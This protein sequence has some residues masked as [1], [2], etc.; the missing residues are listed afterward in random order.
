MGISKNDIDSLTYSEIRSYAFAKAES[1][2]YNRMM[3]MDDISTGY[4]SCKTEK[5]SKNREETYDRIVSS[6]K[7]EYYEKP[8]HLKKAEKEEKRKANKDFFAKISRIK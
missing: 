8:E 6:F 3:L 1:K 5:G 4:A 7:E 2:G